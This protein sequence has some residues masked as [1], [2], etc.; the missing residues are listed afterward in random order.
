MEKNQVTIIGAGPAG[1]AA[2]LQLKLYGIEPV[3]FEKESAGGLLRNANLVENYPGFPEGI[4]GLALVGLF[5]K[6]LKKADLKINKEEV[7]KLDYNGSLFSIETNLRIYESKIVVLASGTKPKK[8]AGVKIS[9][10][11]KERYFYE[12]FELLGEKEKRIT[13]IG[14]GDAAFDY[15]LNLS[16]NN[17]VMILNRSNNIRCR[18]LLFEKA[19][20]CRTISYFSEKIVQKIERD[21]DGLKIHI[22]N[23]DG[24]NKEIILSDFII[25]AVGRESNLDFLKTNIR[26]NI[27]NLIY[28]KRLFLVGDVKNDKYRQ[29]AICTGDGVKAAMEIYETLQIERT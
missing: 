25:S 3:I 11:A 9:D 12:V 19:K 5:K 7:L 10:T 24:S 8:P 27:N 13:I 2:A 23:K 1:I 15:A 6:Q 18:P 20:N 16:K 17:D 26:K 4:T 14:A 28:L 22:S 29:T 21:K